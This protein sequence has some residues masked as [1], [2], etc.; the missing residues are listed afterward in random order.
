MRSSDV[1]RRTILARSNGDGGFAAHRARPSTTESTAWAAMAL[2]SGARRDAALNW[3]LANQLP[4]G[5]WPVGPGYSEPSWMTTSA[6]LALTDN[7]DH[8]GAEESVRRGARWLI[9]QRSRRFPFLNRLFYRLWPD[10]VAVR[11]DIELRAWPWTDGAF[12]WCEP[13]AMAMLA[14]DK[15]DPSLRPGTSAFRWNEG[16]RLLLDR[17]CDGGGWNYGNSLVLGEEL[18]PYPDTT[19]IVLL[20]LAAGPSDP[21]IESSVGALRRMIENGVSTLALSLA[22]LALEAYG[23]DSADLR[24]RVSLQWA[25]APMGVTTRSAALSA[26]VLQG[27]G[28]PFR[29]GE[30]HA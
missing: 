14:I 10:K 17:V 12:A 9:S 18:W 6:L 11:L 15:I 5:A 26:I 22:A 3:L 24:R 27:G 4:G 16:R 30:A 7:P 13:T 8:P 28:S 19:A 23:E 1:A 25:E 2:E 20:S 21:R 29:A